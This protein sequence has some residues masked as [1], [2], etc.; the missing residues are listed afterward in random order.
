[1]FFSQEPARAGAVDME[2]ATVGATQSVMSSEIAARTNTITA[3]RMMDLESQVVNIILC[4][5][6][7]DGNES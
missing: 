1:M 5:Q 7:T 2:M 3:Q 4:N 6:V